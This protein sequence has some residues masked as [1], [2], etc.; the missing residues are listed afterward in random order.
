[1]IEYFKSSEIFGHLKC[2]ILF[3]SFLLFFSSVASAQEQQR[4]LTGLVIDSLREEVSGADVFIIAGK[5]TLNSVTDG[6]GRFLFSGVKSDFISLLIMR[7]G[8]KPF[9][10]SYT[11][12]E[13]QQL[14]NI[15]LIMLHEES[16]L[17]DEV[18]ISGR[19]K[20]IQLKKD[21]IEYNAAF[22]Q[23]SENDRVE[24]LLR[25]LPGVE[26][27][28]N[29]NATTMGKP[30]EKLRVNGEDFF[31]NS[32]KDFISQLPA[33]VVDK[34]QI[35]NDYG[36]EANFTGIKNG[37][38]QKMLN[39]VTKAGQNNGTF[40]NAML[41][42][43]T[44]HRYGIQANGNLWE[45]TKQIG[46]SS[47]SNNTNNDAGINTSAAAGINYRDKLFNG[48]TASAGYNY[49]FNK[50]LSNQYNIIET[51]NPGGTIFNQSES[52]SK[53][54]DNN[55][56]INFN[57]Q[58]I[59][60]KSYFQASLTGS[61]ADKQ[62]SANIN[63]QR[64]GLITQDLLSNTLSNAETPNLSGNFAWAR[65][66]LKPGRSMSAGVNM[67]TGINQ[68]EDDLAN[69]ITYF[70]GGGM[71]QPVDSLVNRFVDT[72]NRTNNVSVDFK[73]SEPLKSDKDSLVK[74][75]ID[76]AYFFTYNR[77]KNSV[78]TRLANSLG[79]LSVLDSLSSLYSSS[80]LLQRFS[81]SYRYQA[82]ELSY[83]LGITAQPSQLT[84]QYLG[85]EIKINH[86]EVNLS[87]IINVSYNVSDW[88]NLAFVYTGSSTAPDFYQL[89]PVPNIS[90]LQNVIVGN[91][92]LKSSFNHSGT[93][94]YQHTS[95]ETGSSFMLSLNGSVVEDQVVSNVILVR[96]TLNSLK[97]ET[98][99]ENANGAYLLGSLYSY[100]V[101]F[102]KNKFN[103]ELKGSWDYINMVS[104]ANGI[105][106]TNRN[107]NF[108]QS[109]RLRMNQ[110]RLTLSGYATYN[111]SSNRYAIAYLRLKNIETWQFNINGR[112]YFSKTIAVNADVSKRIN[113]GYSLNAANPMLINFNIEKTLFKNRQG[114]VKFEAYDL[115]NQGNNLVRSI[116]DNS[117]TDSRYNQITRYFL[118][119]FNYR[120]QN[121]GR[122]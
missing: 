48:I 120:L 81:V 6:R 117:I 23:V 1:M 14:M 42:G 63:S 55:H 99:F 84:G 87:P 122:K 37:E 32:V 21:T 25:Q 82:K 68:V 62:S 38:S 64:R 119:S 72:E 8:Y 89:Q 97:Q 79:N 85:N 115:L 110:R 54:K 105:L 61:L 94:S 111:Y 96:D 112:T 88:D 20:P 52:R 15:G 5:D 95:S 40:G 30:L 45:D 34:I 74:R 100:A 91:P 49:A 59:A 50:N 57:I 36:D 33:N 3:H 92:D 17:L 78:Y 26:I 13:G 67:N 58:S 104:F 103:A 47:S 86:L 118:L 69:R 106:N 27:D 114:T 90:N 4:R 107:I 101:P 83:S 113:S 12:R 43:G 70:N 60:D 2:I 7:V 29:G 66:M 19:D 41:S 65:S 56:N 18:I 71:Q 76:F 28:M 39:L 73:Y 53:S 77:T 93:F 11:F 80:F 108:S 35:I 98:H 24:D 31:T 16:N 102:A 109:L 22:Y 75:N 9:N 44:D 51:I 121:F 116:S 10:K 46:L